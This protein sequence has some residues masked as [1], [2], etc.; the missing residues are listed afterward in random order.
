M[1]V[2]CSS[3]SGT[4]VRLQAVLFEVWG[5][6][7]FEVKVVWTTLMSCRTCASVPCALRRPSSTLTKVL[8]LGLCRT[9][10]WCLQRPEDEKKGRHLF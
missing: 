7:E 2:D 4:E 5:W 3:H 10:V 8:G 6:V 1:V 9:S